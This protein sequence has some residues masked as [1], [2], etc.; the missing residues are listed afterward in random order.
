MPWLL[1]NKL[2]QLQNKA[3]PSPGFKRSLEARLMS[4]IGCN[5]TVSMSWKLAFSMVTAV[6]VVA[7]SG[8]GVY[9]YSSPDV[10]PDTPL[11]GVRLALENVE[12]K[13]AVLPDWRAKVIVKHLK[14]RIQENEIM[15]QKQKPITE[16]RVEMFAKDLKQALDKTNDL[17]EDVKKSTDAVLDEL[18]QKHEDVILSPKNGTSTNE[19]RKDLEK[20]LKQEREKIKQKIQRMDEKRKKHFKRILENR[21]DNANR[22]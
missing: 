17:P 2:H 20:V 13:I 22:K 11:Y 18:E 5:P 9:A 21:R 15:K 12:E 6:M 7:V 14:R 1:K 10:L 4:E 16:G 19:D 8:T 3:L